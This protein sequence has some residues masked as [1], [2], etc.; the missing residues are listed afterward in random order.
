MDKIEGFKWHL[1]AKDHGDGDPDLD[2]MMSLLTDD[3]R[4]Q[5]QDRVKLWFKS[6]LA[7]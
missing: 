3:E 4:T 1:I 7:S 5:V 6:K 2:E